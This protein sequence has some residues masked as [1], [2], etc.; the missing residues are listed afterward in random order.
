MAR[1]RTVDPTITDADKA[2]M[3]TNR[4]VKRMGKLSSH[5]IATD[6]ALRAQRLARAKAV[7]EAV[8]AGSEKSSVDCPP[9]RS[10]ADAVL[11]GRA[12]KITDEQ[13]VELLFENLP[14]S[15]LQAIERLAR[16]DA[17]AMRAALKAK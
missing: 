9:Q 14:I 2:A 7:V 3:R 12:A 16:F 5:A 15:A 17:N 6:E 10:E 4:T 11:L 1:A 13:I 8:V